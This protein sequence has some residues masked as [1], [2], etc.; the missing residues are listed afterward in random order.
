MIFHSHTICQRSVK[1]CPILEVLYNVHIHIQYPH[2]IREY[3][4]LAHYQD[5]KGP[6][7]KYIAKRVTAICAMAHMKKYTECLR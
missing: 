7:R 4:T 6:C 5:T 1:C 3:G 2:F